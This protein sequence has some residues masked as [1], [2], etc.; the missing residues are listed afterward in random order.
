MR[1]KRRRVDEQGHSF[2]SDLPLSSRPGPPLP[3]DT[4]RRILSHCT[5]YRSLLQSRDRSQGTV[6]KLKQHQ[7]NGTVPKSMRSSIRLSLPKGSESDIN[8][9]AAISK[10]YE[11]E[12]LTLLIAAREKELENTLASITSFVDTQTASLRAHY[13]SLRKEPQNALSTS[14]NEDAIVTFTARLRAAL[15]NANSLHEAQRTKEKTDKQKEQ[16]QTEETE[17]EN[18]TKTEPHITAL[19]DSKLSKV[20]ERLVQYIDS[21]LHPPSSPSPR[22]KNQ[23]QPG[24]QLLPTRAIKNQR[25]GKFDSTSPNRGR[26]HR[27]KHSRP[28]SRS[29]SNRRSINRQHRSGPS[30]PPGGADVNRDRGNVNPNA[31]HRMKNSSGNL[32]RRPRS[33]SRR[34]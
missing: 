30:T 6:E 17:E 2:T 28:T 1:R 33:R 15:D 12:A 32:D 8:S 4:D 23:Q 20:M 26:R 34:K 21:K 5:T 14:F 19:I 11:Q 27:R 31:G 7:T 22:P 13:E 3:L 25:E 24:R 9:L 18:S 16:K 10:K 29:P